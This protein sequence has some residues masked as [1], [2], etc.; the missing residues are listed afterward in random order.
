MRKFVQINKSAISMV[1]FLIDHRN[2]VKLF[3]TKVEP[4]VAG[5]W[6]HCNVWSVL[7]SF[8]W[9]IKSTDHGKLLSICFY[10]NINSFWRPFPFS[11]KNRVSKKEKTNCATITAA[12]EKSLSYSKIHFFSYSVNGD[13]RA[14][15]NPVKKCS[16]KFLNRFPFLVLKVENLENSDNNERKTLRSK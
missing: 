3:K 12:C 7:T 2:E 15:L 9:S 5:E 6:F 10:K 13:G 14:T 8:L 11:R 4:R 1:C 16:L